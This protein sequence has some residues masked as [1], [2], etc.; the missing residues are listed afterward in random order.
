M[1]VLAYRFMGRYVAYGAPI[2]SFS[3][4]QLWR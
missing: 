4:E 3:A 1:I 2:I